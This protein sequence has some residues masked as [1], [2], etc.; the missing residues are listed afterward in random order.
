MKLAQAIEQATNRWMTWKISKSTQR[1]F[2]IPKG[3][4]YLTGFVIHCG[5]LA[6][7]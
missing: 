1:E 2:G 4:P 6:E 7:Q 3:L 5:I